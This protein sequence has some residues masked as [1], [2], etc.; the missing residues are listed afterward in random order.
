MDDNKQQGPNFK[1]TEDIQICY[2]WVGTSED[3]TVGTNM[4]TTE[5]KEKFHQ[6]YATLIQKHNNEMFTDYSTQNATR[7]YNRFKK[8]SHGL[9]KY[10]GTE[11]SVGSPPSG[12]TD[13]EKWNEKVEQLFL[14]RFPEFIKLVETIQ[15]CKDI[16]GDKPKW[17]AFQDEEVKKSQVKVAI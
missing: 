14:K 3:A 4:K 7:C 2:A 10:L 15:A 1:L 11:N 8:I 13:K 12:D 6:R 17:R 5:F 16:L 9:L